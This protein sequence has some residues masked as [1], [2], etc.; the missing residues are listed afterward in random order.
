MISLNN[1]PYPSGLMIDFQEM[2]F[3]LAGLQALLA[4]FFIAEFAHTGIMGLCP[5]TGGG[6]FLQWWC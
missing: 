2:N 5:N 4:R 1:R 6:W 3:N